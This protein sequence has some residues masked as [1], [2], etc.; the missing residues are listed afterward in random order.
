[1]QL[2]RSSDTRFKHLNRFKIQ[3]DR[4][5]LAESNGCCAGSFSW[6]GV[7]L[8]VSSAIAAG[9][10]GAEGTITILYLSRGIKGTAAFNA[11][12]MAVF[13]ILAGFLAHTSIQYFAKE[14]QNQGHV[15]KRIARISFFL[16]AAW[17]AFTLYESPR[18]FLHGLP[19]IVVPPAAAVFLVIS[20]MLFATSRSRQ[21]ALASSSE[22]TGMIPNPERLQQ[23]RWCL[24]AGHL[25][26]F[27]VC[28]VLLVSRILIMQQKFPLDRATMTTRTLTGLKL[29]AVCAYALGNFAHRSA[30]NNPLQQVSVDAAGSATVRLPPCLAWLSCSGDYAPSQ[31]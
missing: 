19:Y 11:V 29:T 20:G 5:Y 7:H 15:P 30:L 21:F 28:L 27:G 13:A 17:A 8:Q 2:Y 14:A 22:G 25:F 24:A 26:M 12:E 18:I 23:G 10:A 31:T 6:P 16:G 4:A 9:L 3:P 1:M